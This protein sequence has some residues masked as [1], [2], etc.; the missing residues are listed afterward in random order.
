MSAPPPPPTPPPPL[1]PA[2]NSTV[3]APPPGAP[4]PLKGEGATSKPTLFEHESY[5]LQ[6]GNKLT[7][8]DPKSPQTIEELESLNEALATYIQTTMKQEIHF[9]EHWLPSEDADGGKCCIYLTEN[10]T[11]CT[12]LLVVLQN[13]VGSQPGIW[14]RSLCM[15]NGLNAGSML[16]T[17]LKAASLGYGIAVLNPNANS[18]VNEDGK[19]CSILTSSTPTEH[20]IT[21]WDDI[22]Y[23]QTSAEHI[24]LLGYGN[25][26]SLAKDILLRQMAKDNVEL[27]RI[28]GIATIESSQTVADDDS[29]DIK[30]FLT[31]RSINWDSN[32]APAQYKLE[33]SSKKL[34]TICL[35]AGPLPEKDPNVAFS[36]QQALDPA[37]RFFSFIHSADTGAGAATSTKAVVQLSRQFHTSEAAALKMSAADCTIPDVAPVEEKKT[38]ISGMKKLFSWRSKPGEAE[39]EPSGDGKSLGVKDFDLLKV[40]GKGAFGKVMLVRKKVAPSAGQIFAMKV[41]KKSV[42]A[43]KGQVEHTKSER[44][45]LFEVRHPF[46]VFL[47]FAFQSDEKLY[48]ITDFYAGGSLFY[49]LR[50]SR[51]FSEVRARFYASELLLAL[52]HL[53]S[54]QIIYRDLKLENVL[55]DGQGHVA[56]TDFGLSKQHVESSDAASTFCGTAEYIAPELLRGKRYGAAVD[57]WSFGILLYEMQAGRTPFYDKNRKIMFFNIMNSTPQFPLSFSEKACS[58]LRALLTVDPSKRLGV[59]SISDLKA[60]KFFS[61]IDWDKLFAKEIRPVYIPDVSNELDCKYVPKTYLRAEAKDSICQKMKGDDKLDF[62]EFTYAGEQSVLS[63]EE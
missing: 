56:L 41:L 39:E 24:F 9:V 59:S 52:A 54:H 62:Q 3:P 21:C 14:S 37:F 45:I 5:E 7:K 13:H 46:V 53:H 4:P 22:I 42:I 32:N 31:T 11:T 58:V 17:L 40:V 18:Y 48:L 23:P 43:A 25:G 26:G 51:C 30:E 44:D 2:S 1:P 27:N 20:V 15:D 47:R 55:M 50:K 19:K 36:I 28:K 29:Q 61:S 16:P 8:K 63:N 49:H 57:W 60:H 35:S 10:L 6:D 34:G 33:K 38:I 12:K